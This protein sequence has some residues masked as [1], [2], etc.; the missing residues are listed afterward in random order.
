MFK[1]WNSDFS[2]QFYNN[3]STDF[4]ENFQSQHR[5]LDPCEWEYNV[6]FFWGVK[7][8]CKS[9]FKVIFPPKSQASGAS[10]GNF[11]LVS[12][13]LL[14]LSIAQDFARQLKVTRRASP[15]HNRREKSSGFDR[16][17]HIQKTKADGSRL[18]DQP[19]TFTWQKTSDL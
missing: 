3:S 5:V 13:S 2:S 16:P 14:P 9:L 18:E 17:E 7:C 4:T 8:F 19:M 1:S 10:E 15:K 12:L 11:N 6:D